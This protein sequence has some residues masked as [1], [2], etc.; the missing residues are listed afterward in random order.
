MQADAF[1]HV[2]DKSGKKENTKANFFS[3]FSFFLLVALFSSVLFY[4][5][6]FALAA[7]SEEE[8]QIILINGDDIYIRSGQCHTFLQDYQ[9]Y[10]KG[11]DIDGKRIWLELRR[12]GISLQDGIATEGSQFVYTQNSTE[13]FNLTV[14]TIYEGADGVLVKF[15]PVYQYLNPKLPMPQTQNGSSNNYSENT[16][17]EFPELEN[18]AEGFSMPIFLLSLGAVLLVT[19]LFAGKMKRK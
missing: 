7:D 10:V 9:L 8:L 16:S 15:S 6:S 1:M 14:S 2:Q 5:M 19:S 4:S 18:Q 17:S 3:A 12:E 11:A 13:V